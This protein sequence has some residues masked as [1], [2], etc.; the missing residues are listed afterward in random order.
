MNREVGI[1]L[2]TTTKLIKGVVCIYSGNLYKLG[3]RLPSDLSGQQLY[4]V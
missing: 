2:R 1:H 4:L 3:I